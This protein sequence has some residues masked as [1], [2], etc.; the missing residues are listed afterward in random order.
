MQECDRLIAI[1]QNATRV[2]NEAVA[3][4][5]ARLGKPVASLSHAPDG[6]R[7][8]RLLARLQWDA[9]EQHSARKTSICESTLINYQTVRT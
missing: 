4:L 8:T 2:A 9:S 5:V 3:T 6:D 1:R 7:N